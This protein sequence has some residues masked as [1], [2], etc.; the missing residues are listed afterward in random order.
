[1]QSFLLAWLLAC[2]ASSPIGLILGWLYCRS[3]EMILDVDVAA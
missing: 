2:N 3:A 1:M